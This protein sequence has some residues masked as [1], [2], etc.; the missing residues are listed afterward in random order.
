MDSSTR[1]RGYADSHQEVLAV[2]AHL[3]RT[4]LGVITGYLQLLQLRDD[5]E[6]RADALRE[7]EAAAERL[8]CT[9][10]VLISILETEPRE[11]SER[12]V[13]RTRA[14]ETQA[15]RDGDAHEDPAGT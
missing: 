7:I 8:V 12:V 6:L 5:P 10:N 3:F 2:V 9:V 13:A 4:P 11:L 1:D 15:L 14:L